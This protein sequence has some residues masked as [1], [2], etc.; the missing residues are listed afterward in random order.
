MRA[1]WFGNETISL[2]GDDF[3]R[4]HRLREGRYD[5][6]F[7]DNLAEGTGLSVIL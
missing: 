1:G 2:A 4:S 7:Q 5:F 6:Q 3:V